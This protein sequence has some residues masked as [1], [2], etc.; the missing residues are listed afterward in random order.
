[1]SISVASGASESER[2]RETEQRIAMEEE[3]KTH[4]CGLFLLPGLGFGGKMGARV[5][6]V[7]G[8]LLL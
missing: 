8:N 3:M 5:L 6:V 2:E 4:K 7:A 1:M